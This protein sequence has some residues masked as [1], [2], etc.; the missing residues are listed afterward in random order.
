VFTAPDRV[1]HFLWGDYEDS[2]T[3][4]E[5]LIA[6]HAALDGHVG[7]IREALP[8]DVTLVVGST[9]GFRRLRYDVYCNEWLEREGWLSYADD[10]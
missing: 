3:Y 4:R 7:S 9:H 8:D 2:G 10:D 5:E 1:N 6:F